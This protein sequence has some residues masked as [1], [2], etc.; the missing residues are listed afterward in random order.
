[1]YANIT[2]AKG[3]ELRTTLGTNVTNLQTNLYSGRNLNFISRTQGGMAT[4]TS[5]QNRYWS[6]ESYLT[7]NNK[8]C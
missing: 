8:V 6:S 5:S 2:L 3:L 1:M 7:Y 4:V